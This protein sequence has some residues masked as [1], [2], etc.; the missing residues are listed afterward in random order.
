MTDTLESLGQLLR[1]ERE[2]K[3]LSVEDVA[4]GL[5][6]SVRVLRAL[7]AGDSISLPHIVYVRGFI[8]AYGKYLDMD[9][10]GLLDSPAL[11][12]QKEPKPS[13]VPFEKPEAKKRKSKVGVVFVVL[14]F[15]VFGGGVGVW[16]YKNTQVF[17]MLNTKF[18]GTAEPAPALSRPQAKTVTTALKVDAKTVVSKPE[19][20]D[21]K[22]SIQQQPAVAVKK[23]VVKTKPVTEVSK[24]NASRDNANKDNVNS[25]VKKPTPVAMYDR[26]VEKDNT[27]HLGPHKVIITAL[28]ASWIQSAADNTGK[29]KFSLQPGDTFA[30]T[31][32]SQLNLILG[33]AGGVQIHYNGRKMPPLGKK[34]EEKSV[35]F[36]PQT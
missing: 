8:S 35:T 17:S 28:A 10:Q 9:V 18:L 1:A 27:P 20:K 29:R 30:L 11:N 24:N 6:I 26:K 21:L 16:A 23:E 22:I 13:P 2:T 5:K 3:N 36:P 31:F 34:G 15:L 32:D 25:T 4:D 7:E 14:V 33:N 19:V 12:E